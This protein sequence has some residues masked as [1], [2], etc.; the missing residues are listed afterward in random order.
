MQMMPRLQDRGGRAIMKMCLQIVCCFFLFLFFFVFFVFD[1]WVTA[2][3]STSGRDLQ[4]ASS[5]TGLPKMGMGW[6]CIGG[7]W[8]QR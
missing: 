2:Q 7:S 1:S 3:R 6:G 8:L 4:T 5:L